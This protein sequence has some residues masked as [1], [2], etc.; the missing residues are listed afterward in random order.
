MKKTSLL[1]LVGAL[2][3]TAG[4]FF[5]PSIWDAK[6]GALFCRPDGVACTPLDIVPCCGNCSKSICRGSLE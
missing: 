2:L 6:A 3:I 4:A 5:T 1:K